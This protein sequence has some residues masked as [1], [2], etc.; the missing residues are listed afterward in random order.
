MDAIYRRDRAT[1]AEVRE[2][3][4]DA[5]SYSAVRTLLRI[6]EDKGHVT[7]T[8]EG[9][10]YVY[11]PTRPRTRAG[12][13]ALRRVLRTFYE[14]SVENVV[15]ALLDISEDGLSEEEVRRLRRLIHKTRREGR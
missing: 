2:D 15:A 14:G 8:E 7:H 1:V 3:L 9:G 13:A 5:P 10:R 12:H 6:L 4:P 11:R